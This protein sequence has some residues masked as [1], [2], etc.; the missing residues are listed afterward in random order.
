LYYEER[1]RAFAK[2]IVDVIANE[3]RAEANSISSFY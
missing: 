1:D 2:A 3:V